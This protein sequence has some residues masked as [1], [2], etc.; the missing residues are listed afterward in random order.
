MNMFM[1]RQWIAINRAKAFFGSPRLA[2]PEVQTSGCREAKST[3]V[4][5]KEHYMYFSPLQRTWYFGSRTL[6]C[7]ATLP[8]VFRLKISDTTYRAPTIALVICLILA[9]CG[10]ETPTPAALVPSVMPKLLATVEIS[11]TPNQAEQEATRGASPPTATIAPIVP[12]EQPTAYVGVFL[13]EAQGEDG[14]PVIEPALLNNQP[15]T[16]TSSFNAS[17]CSAIP[18]DAKLGTAWTDDTVVVQRLGCPIEFMASYKGSL[19]IF[20]RGVMY[21]R[22]TGEIW[23]VAPGDQRYWYV[24]LAPPPPPVM[25]A[26]PNG[27]RVPALGFGGVWSSVPGVKDAIGYA[28]TDEQQASLASQRFQGG[29]IL[30]DFSSGQV[31]VFYADST[32]AGPFS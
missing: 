24:P 20:E 15:A 16:A 21:W 3:E 11:P 32:L 29:T 1:K 14:G 10:T 22:P 17:L 28:Q 6:E 9:A 19:Q 13:G 31:F 7:L 18:P 30:V 2:P 4:D 8:G 27:L 12:T 5:S 23:A 26:A 25:E